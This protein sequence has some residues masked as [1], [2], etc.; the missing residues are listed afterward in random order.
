MKKMVDDLVYEVRSET[1]RA[2]ISSTIST[3]NKLSSFEKKTNKKAKI[4]SEKCPKCNKG[5]II[6]G[7]TAYG[8]NNY[9][10]GCTFRLPF[11]FLD[12]KISQNQYIRL[13]Q[14]GCTV[15]LKGF[16]KETET[17]EGLVRFDKNFNLKLETKNKNNSI[18][19]EI[20]TYAEMTNSIP[21]KIRCPKCKK[22]T[23]LKGKIAY[24][25]SNFKN[26]C[27]FIF[28]FNEIRKKA[29]GQTLSKELV[30]NIL[31]GKY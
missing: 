3:K 12:K 20:P 13:L 23:I 4:S 7:K 31:N 5:F 18:N 27:N 22:G 24:G 6:K 19:H 2:N 17:V 8:C 9:K 11:S 30:Y 1:V 14:K 15:K 10:N 16:K 21:D 26:G 25:C 29:A 28:S